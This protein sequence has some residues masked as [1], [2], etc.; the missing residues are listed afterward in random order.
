MSQKFVKLRKNC[1]KEI[2]ASNISYA[3]DCLRS[4]K[5]F[6]TF[7]M[8]KIFDS[9]FEIKAFF[10]DNFLRESVL[11][12]VAPPCLEDLLAFLNRD[13]WPLTS[14]LT[15]KLVLTSESIYH[16]ELPVR[17]NRYIH[18]RTSKICWVSS[19][20]KRVKL[21]VDTYIQFF[22]I[23]YVLLKPIGFHIKRLLLPIQGEHITL[24]NFF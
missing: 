11:F 13:T 22:T 21:P 17:A 1:D 9:H 20:Y 5:E 4:F 16:H 7:F 23:M 18:C 8:A 12:H 10:V 24:P 3:I 19:K 2:S 6:G 15:N 14:I